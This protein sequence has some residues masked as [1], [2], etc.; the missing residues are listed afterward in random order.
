MKTILRSFISLLML[1]LVLVSCEEDALDP[2]TGKYTHP[3]VCDYTVI[4]SEMREKV[5]TLFE[6]SINLKGEGINTLNLKLYSTNYALPT[7]DYTQSEAAALNT[8]LIGAEGS[9]CN[10][11]QIIGNTIFVKANGPDYDVEG[12]LH[13]AD[14]TVVRMTASFSI[15][16]EYV[17]IYTYSV[18]LETPAMGG[19]QGDVVIAGAT[20]HK[21]SIFADGV[22]TS[23]LE[24]IADGDNYIMILDVI[25][26]NGSY[27]TTYS[28]PLSVTVY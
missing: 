23:Y 16:Y 14:V 26:D 24:V 27:Q 8:Y 3:D 6:F 4:D 7:S 22:M 15:V 21:L 13:L 28:G 1:A 9:T 5:G 18:E 10:G 20:K 19:A 12:I 25:T 17:P 2:L 11:Q